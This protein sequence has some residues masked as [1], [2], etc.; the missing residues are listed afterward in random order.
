MGVVR[1]HTGS[2]SLSLTLLAAF[3]LIAALIAYA[4]NDAPVA[5]AEAD[6]DGM[7]MANH[8]GRKPVAGVG[9][10]VGGRRALW[11]SGSSHAR[12][13]RLSSLNPPTT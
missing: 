8:I 11:Q 4:L 7:K 3:A 9:N 13:C 1:D 5:G 12:D 6:N 2:F 10:G